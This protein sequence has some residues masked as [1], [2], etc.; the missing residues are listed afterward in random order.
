MS[1]YYHVNWEIRKVSDAE[2]SRITEEILT[3]VEQNY[4]DGE[5]DWSG[6]GDLTLSGGYGPDEYASHMSNSIFELLGRK[7]PIEFTV[8]HIEQAPQDTFY[9]PEGLEDLEEWDEAEEG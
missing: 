2:I 4:Y 3:D 9:F 1:R 5:S 6:S 7:V 8:I